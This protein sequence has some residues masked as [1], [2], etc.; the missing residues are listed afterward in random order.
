ML[1][2]LCIPS[3]AAVL[4]LCCRFWP[5]TVGF[6]FAMYA[7]VGASSGAPYHN[8]SCAPPCYL[9]APAGVQAGRSD[10]AADE[11]DRA[12]HASGGSCRRHCVLP[13]HHRLMEYIHFLQLRPYYPRRAGAFA[14][15]LH[16]LLCCLHPQHLPF[17]Y[18]V[19]FV[20]PT[21]SLP[22][23]PMVDAR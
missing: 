9:P 7:K 3:T 19:S 5:L 2:R 16:W 21:S 1:V 22:P 23:L 12:C 14:V 11:S 10:A 17:S 13:E 8:R 6:P 15:M 4:W 20:L 18:L